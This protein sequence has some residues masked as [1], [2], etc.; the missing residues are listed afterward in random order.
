MKF[1]W[2]DRLWKGH[3][4]WCFHRSFIKTFDIYCNWFVCR[5][6]FVAGICGSLIGYA[7][8]VYQM[9][10]NREKLTNK[11]TIHL[12]DQFFFTLNRRLT[13]MRREEI[14]KMTIV[15]LFILKTNL[16]WNERLNDRKIILRLLI[17]GDVGSGAAEREKKGMT[18]RGK[19]VVERR[20][21]NNLVETIN[22]RPVVSCEHEPSSIGW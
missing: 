17:A 4:N 3:E 5:P 21:K 19:Y 15:W 10:A 14:P 6:R 2:I 7:L 8:A 13:W 11:K 20:K 12:H 9:K 18:E 16:Q 1:N 22:D